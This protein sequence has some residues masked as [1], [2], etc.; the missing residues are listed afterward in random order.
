MAMEITKL[1]RYAHKKS[2]GTDTRGVLMGSIKRMG[3]AVVIRLH[4]H[5]ER[6]INNDTVNSSHKVKT[7]SN[8]QSLFEAL[9]LHSLLMQWSCHRVSVGNERYSF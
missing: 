8:L 6:A 1:G 2:V 7:L 4:R 9:V 3:R 5:I